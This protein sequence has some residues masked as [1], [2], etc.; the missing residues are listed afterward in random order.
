MDPQGDLLVRL[1]ALEERLA[2]EEI[3]RRDAEEAA[4]VA[5][6]VKG[7]F[8]SNMSHELRTPLNGLVGASELALQLHLPAEAREYVELIH[9]SALALFEVVG[10]I[11]D[12]A[13]LDAGALELQPVTFDV[14]AALAAT[15][16]R[17]APAAAG[18]GLAL[19]LAGGATPPLPVQV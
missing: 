6:E 11:L 1:A 19:S 16:A 14:R 5:V 7:R 4:R 15:I 13:R 8:L 10:G 9:R 2:R 18:K 17:H 12:V 3:A